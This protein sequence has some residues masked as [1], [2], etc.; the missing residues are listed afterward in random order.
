MAAGRKSRDLFP[1]KKVRYSGL[2]WETYGLPP[3]GTI[4]ED[5]WW[6]LT[7]IPKE[8]KTIDGVASIFYTTTGPITL[9]NG[10]ATGDDL[11]SRDGRK[12]KIVSIHLSTVNRLTAT[13][14]AAVDL[15]LWLVYD[16]RPGGAL[17]VYSDIFDLTASHLLNLNNRERF[18]VLWTSRTAVGPYSLVAP[19]LGSDAAK[20]IECFIDLSNDE[21]VT[22]FNGTGATI[23][24]IAYGAIYLV[25]R[26]ITAITANCIYYS[27][28]RFT[29]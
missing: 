15:N 2:N 7:G 11:N 4:E 22:V 5:V 17:P 3:S 18:S 20:C 29:E 16:R 1:W 23:A 26:S 14:S 28:I 13:S 8:L 21:V 24:D 25:N 9:L 10:I 12:L 19:V 6:E 27:R